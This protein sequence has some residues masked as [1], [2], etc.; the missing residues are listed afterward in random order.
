LRKRPGPR[1]GLWTDLLAF[2]QVYSLD[3]S[4]G[5]FTGELAGTG[6]SLP[7]GSAGER[8]VASGRRGVVRGRGSVTMSRTGRVARGRYELLL[9]FK[10]RG[11][12]TTLSQ[13]IRVR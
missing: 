8:I 13:R 4:A 11:E 6:G 7:Q 9:A 12:A 2:S 3:T 5:F 10:S 1:F